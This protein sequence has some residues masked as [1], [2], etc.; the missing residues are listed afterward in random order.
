MA[1]AISRVAVAGI[2]PA[3]SGAASTR[4]PLLGAVEGR[5]DT[6]SVT[7]FSLP[8]LRQKSN[9]LNPFNLILAVQSHSEKFFALPVGQII[10]TSPRHLVPPEG[11]LATRTRGGMRWTQAVLLT[12]AQPCGRRSRVVLTPR[13]WRQ[14]GDNAHALRAGDGDNKARF[15]RE[16]TK[17]T[18]KTTARG[19][20]GVSG[21][22]VVTNSCAFYFCTRGCGRVERPAFPAPSIG[23]KIYCGTRAENAC[24]IANRV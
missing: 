14:H 2:Y 22:T 18:V 12:R 23:R 10:S 5:V 21:V 6:F 1:C 13:R 19:M 16:S 4:R 8:R 11:R 7:K 20:P 15:T 3:I 24:G 17:E 9:L